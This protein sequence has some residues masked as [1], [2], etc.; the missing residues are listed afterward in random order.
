MYYPYY[1]QQQQWRPYPPQ[2]PIPNIIRVP[3]Y[4]DKCARLPAQKIGF[5][6]NYLLSICA[7]IRLLL[8]VRISWHV[9]GLK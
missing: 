9:F 1:H 4:D 8:M 5:N 2:Q 6:K 3:Y 7:L